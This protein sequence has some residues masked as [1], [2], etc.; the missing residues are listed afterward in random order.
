MRTG[1]IYRAASPSGKFYIGQTI[2][3]LERR[4]YLH[5]FNENEDNTK[6][7]KALRKYKKEDW[8]WEALSENIPERYLNELEVFLIWL[9][10]SYK[11]GYNSTIGGD[12]NPMKN[13]ETRKKISKA[14]K[15]KKRTEEMNRKNSESHLGEKNHFFGKHHNEETKEKISQSRKIYIGNKNPFFGK[16]HS[17]ETRNKIAFKNSKITYKITKPAGSTEIIKNLKK[18]CREN[19]LIPSCMHRVGRKEAKHHKGY[20]VEKIDG[21]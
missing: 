12:E 3:K 9:H 15:G 6:F 19:N 16:H 4:K 2:M 11:T 5:F 17:E 20:L 13:P 1:I 21:K 8:K 10:D 18:Y 14:N 7:H